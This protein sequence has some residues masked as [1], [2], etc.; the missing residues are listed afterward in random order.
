MAPR[1]LDR[2]ALNR[3]LLARQHLLERTRTPPLEAVEQLVGLQAQA[4]LV[5]YYALWSRLEGFDPET[6]SALLLERTVVRA[7]LLRTTVHLVSARDL[8]ALRPLTQSVMARTFESTPFAKRIGGVDREPLLAQGRALMEERPRTR[9][10]LGRLLTEGWPGHDPAALA[11]AVTYLVPTVQVT[12]RGV[13]GARGQ[14]TLT[15]PEA[16]LGRPLEERGSPEA[17]VER[18]LAAFGPA[19]V[20]DARTWSGLAGLR[21]VVD[22]MRPRLQTFRDERGTELLDVPDGLLPDPG[23]PAPPRFL[24][25]Y[26]NVALSHADRSRIVP[27]DVRIPIPPGNGGSI[28]TFTIDGFIRG[29]W[30]M[31]RA[32]DAVTLRL[33]PASPLSE[34]EEAEVAEEGVAL[35][36]FGAPGARPRVEVA[37]HTPGP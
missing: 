9:A 14:A 33:E 11:Q 26:D 29:M 36:A 3:A 15:T 21:E 17:W 27:R 28:G 10:E 22:G 16:W 32:G 23:T 5:P 2:R 1:V 12:P 37:R 20:A 34:A 25:E 4:P 30:R 24:P 6:L 35:M 19:S 31:A 13:W 18:Y 8:L 7:A